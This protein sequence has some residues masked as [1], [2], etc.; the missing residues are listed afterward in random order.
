MSQVLIRGCG[1]RLGNKEWITGG[2]FKITGEQAE[3][4]TPSTA[5]RVYVM[6][7]SNVDDRVVAW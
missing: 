7:E 3:L 6:G 4:S 5:V 1:E 2:Y